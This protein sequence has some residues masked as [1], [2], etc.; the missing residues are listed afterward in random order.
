M[1]ASPTRIIASWQSRARQPD[2][3]GEVV[4]D[5]VCVAWERYGA[6]APVPG[7]PTI[8]LLPTWSIVHS[9]VWK[10]QVPY[11]ARQFRVLT[12]DGRGNGRSDRPSSPSAYAAHEFVEDAVAVL[13]ATSTE[14][15]VIVGFSMGGGYALRLAAEHPDRVLGA[16]LVAPAAG[17]GIPHP[18]RSNHPF[19][20]DLGIDEGWLRENAFS[21]RRDWRG[22][23]EFFMGEVLSEP[24]STKPIED[25]VGWALETDPETMIRIDAAPFMEHEAD[26]VTLTGRDA[27]L[28]YLARVRC[29]AL[30]I[31]GTD[32]HVIPFEA[33]R[34]VAEGLRAPL[35][36]F[37]GGG[38][39]PLGRD[40]VRVNLLIRDFVRGLGRRP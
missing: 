14:R 17:L 18:D 10:L 31:H 7:Q 22:Y 1:V 8:L 34:R 26:G 15:A 37:E 23:A 4:R 36:A 27:A 20:E 28:D 9:R 11:L 25:M 12:F 5:G 6:A 3:S 40:P 19:D 32:D 30:V 29:P 33:G 38:H 2:A 24:H 13:D 21:W 16:V 39:S 35:V